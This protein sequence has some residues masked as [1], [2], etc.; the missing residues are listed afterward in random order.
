MQ[1]SRIKDRASRATQCLEEAWELLRKRIPK[2]P[3]VV[4]VVLNTNSRRRLHGAFVP[5][6]WRYRQAKKVHEIGISPALF[7]TPADLLGTLLHEAAHAVL[8]ETDA[9]NPRH[10]AG[11]SVGKDRYYHRTEFR[12]TCRALGLECLFRNRRYG[13]AL[14][15]WPAA[16]VPERY[17]PILYLLTRALPWGTQA[18]RLQRQRLPGAKTPAAG[19]TKLLCQC[20]KPRGIYVSQAVKAAGGIVCL[21]CHTEFRAEDHNAEVPLYAEHEEPR[22]RRALRHVPVSE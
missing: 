18:H 20:A 16:G 22:A 3:P 10:I 6:T 19:H 9:Q 4:V 2:L 8:F 1:K 11:C 13:W 17:Q 15:Q 5:S 21:F 14:T 12:E 7:P